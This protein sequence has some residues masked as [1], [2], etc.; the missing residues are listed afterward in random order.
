MPAV[1]PSH[2]MALETIKVSDVKRRR[3]R[4]Q[5]QSLSNGT[6]NIEISTL[7]GIFRE[8]LEMDAIDS[9]P[10]SPVRRPPVNQRDWYISRDDFNRIMEVEQG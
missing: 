7:I 3:R 9:N 10:C 8:Q 1:W 4:R 6:I 5:S 2:S